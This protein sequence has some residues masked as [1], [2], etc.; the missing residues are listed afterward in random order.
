MKKLLYIFMFICPLLMYSQTQNQLSFYELDSPSYLYLLNNNN[1]NSLFTSKNFTIEMWVDIPMN[2]VNISDIFDINSIDNNSITST[3]S[4]GKNGDEIHFAYNNANINKTYNS[5]NV[6]LNGWNHIALISNNF[7]IQIVINGTSIYSIDL[8]TQYKDLS[9][10]LFTINAS[11]IATIPDTSRSKF[12]NIG[13]LKY[14]EIRIW[15]TARTISQIKNNMF[16]LLPLTSDLTAYYTFENDDVSTGA[17]SDLTS[18]KFTLNIYGTPKL[19]ATTS[20]V[21]QNTD[22]SEVITSFNPQASIDIFNINSDATQGGSALVTLSNNQQTGGI[23]GVN[24]IY[25]KVL[26]ITNRL[27]DSAN[28]KFEINN[29]NNLQLDTT[30]LVLIESYDNI[31]SNTKILPMQKNDKGNYEASTIFGDADQEYFYTI[32]QSSDINPKITSTAGFGPFIQGKSQ[33]TT[34]TITS[35]PSGTDSVILYN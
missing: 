20:P 35:M 34:F 33:I 1:N 27:L 22:S 30:K 26:S 12:Q 7:N 9:K 8:S 4:L 28:L 18:N 3:L 24:K 11:N 15:S 16:K 31:F 14:D 19:E 29:L 25:S 2:A 17:I 6:L 13:N 21:Y 5:D 23:S 10:C 32:G